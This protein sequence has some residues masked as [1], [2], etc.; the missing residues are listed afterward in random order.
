MHWSK[1]ADKKE[2]QDLLKALGLIFG[3]LMLVVG[4]GGFLF[5]VSSV[6]DTETGKISGITRIMM[7]DPN[8]YVY[9]VSDVPKPQ[10]LQMGALPD[11]IYDA[12]K[13]SNMWVDYVCNKRRDG[14]VDSCRYIIHLHSVR[15]LEGGAWNHGKFG[16]GQNVV[17]E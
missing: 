5:Y 15:E 8:R 9:F 12:P 4:G 6:V 17:L 16:Q 11:I 10:V 14:R 2:L 7:S 3:L 1:I 13:E